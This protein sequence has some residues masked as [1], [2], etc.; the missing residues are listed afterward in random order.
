MQIPESMDECLYFTNRRL[1]D[2]T[3]ILAWVRKKQCP[4]CGNALMGKPLDAKTGRP[5]VRATVYACPGCGHEE[6]KKDH[7]ADLQ[8]EVEYSNPEGTETKNATTPYK[9]KTFQ[10]IPSFVFE[11][12]FTGE[13]TGITKK[14]KA[15]KAKK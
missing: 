6:S 10:G 7:E 15:K 11:N 8:V 1:P 13:K 5:K 12:E 4:A 9:R 2:G 3:K 14:M